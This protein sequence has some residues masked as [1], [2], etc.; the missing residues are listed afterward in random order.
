LDN[1]YR[2]LVAGIRLKQDNEVWVKGYDLQL[3]IRIKPNKIKNIRR[4]FAQPVQG[5]YD[6]G[7][8]GLWDRLTG[9][10]EKDFFTVTLEQPV[11]DGY[12]MADQVLDEVMGVN[13]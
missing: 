13:K 6:L 8:D 7:G 9:E 4:S 12:V 5:P 10:D 1:L 2:F 11:R 3:N